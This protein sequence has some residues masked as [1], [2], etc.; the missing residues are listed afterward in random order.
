MKNKKIII[1]LAALVAVL[2]AVF[3]VVL[4]KNLPETQKGDKDILVTVVYEDKSEKE[5]E[6]S[7][8]AEFLADALLEE[9]L[10]KEDEYKS[11][12]YTYIDGVRADYNKD[13]AWWC[14]TKGGEMTNAGMNELPVAD[15]DEFE[16]TH[17]PS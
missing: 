8:D 11:G 4:I 6:I 13:G 2:V 16:I 15:G 9:K 17:T 14:V 5:F 12:F 7:T 1:G 3:G 10:I